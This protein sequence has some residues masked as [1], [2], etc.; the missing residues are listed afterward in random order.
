MTPKSPYRQVDAPAFTE[1]VLQTAENI[2]PPM[3]VI[4]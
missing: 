4:I 1:L 3:A 2:F